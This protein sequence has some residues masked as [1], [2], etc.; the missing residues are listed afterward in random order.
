M[1]ALGLASVDADAGTPAR[2]GRPSAAPTET[3]AL[4]QE[5]EALRAEVDA[6]TRRLDAQAAQ[7]QA[8]SA[9][10]IA[11]VEADTGRILTI[12]AQVETATRRAEA[13][14]GWWGDTKVGGVMFADIS[15]IDNRNAAGR[16][17]Q[18]GV[19]FD[20]K[21]MYLS[22]D[23]R[24]NDVWSFNVTSDLTFDSNGASP[25][26]GAAPTPNEAGGANTASGVKSTQLF[27]KKAFLQARFSDAV[28]VRLGEAELPWITFIE[29]ANGYRYVEPVL[30][31]RGRFGVAFDWGVHLYG[32]LF[33]HILSYQLSVFDGQ[34]F[35]QPSIGVANRTDT[36]DVEGRISA[37]YNHVTVAVG[38]YDG[39]LGGGVTGVA[40]Y[41]DARRFD[42]L[43]FYGDARVRVGVEYMSARYWRDVA[44]ANSARTNTSEAWSAFGSWTITPKAAVFGRYDRVRPLADT[45]PSE[46]DD[47]F[48]I[49]LS[50]RPIAALDFALVYKRDSVLNG[51]LSTGDGVIGIPKGAVTGEGIYDEIGLYTQVKF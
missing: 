30:V 1:G 48:D 10:A 13:K 19:D 35:K 20:I 40:T 31:D 25:S 17:A 39:K 49:G 37:T 43:A 16:T 44:Q 23:H 9:Q 15:S 46:H 11:R 47:F 7:S 8:L 33:D 41:H 12:P 14:P 51:S 45:A 27:L 4:K 18:S 50:Y 32:S 22:V 26:G 5:V 28:N 2:H 34:G 24:F 38:G 29:N 36:M 42:A 6:L 21:R 3:E